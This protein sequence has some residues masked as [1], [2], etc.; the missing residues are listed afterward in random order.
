MSVDHNPE[1]QPCSLEPNQDDLSAY[2]GAIFRYATDGAYLTHRVYLEKSGPALSTKGLQV[3]D[4]NLDAQV[5][6]AVAKARMAANHQKP[7]VYCLP[8]A[9][10]SCATSARAEDLDEVYTLTVD[11]DQRPAESLRLLQQVLG[12]PTVVVESGAEWIN[13]ETGAVEKKLHVHWRLMEPATGAEVEHLQ[14]ARRLAAVKVGGDV[15]AASPVHAFRAPGSFHRKATPRLAKIAALRPDME[16]DLGD[17]LDRLREM[18][19]A[20]WVARVTGGLQP[21]RGAYWQRRTHGD[22]A[23]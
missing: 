9:G 23:V 14:K 15:S 6:E 13:H 20:P 21:R 10:F 16:I 17:A 22:P 11:L 18:L 7:A 8:L 4:G 5:V 12:P 19:P 2:F 3:K 1:G